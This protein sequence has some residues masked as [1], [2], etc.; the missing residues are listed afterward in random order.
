MNQGVSEDCGFAVICT[1][2]AV[3]LRMKSGSFG[4]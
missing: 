4:M 2:F 1:P 3:S